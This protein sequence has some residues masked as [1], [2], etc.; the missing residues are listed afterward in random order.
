MKNYYRVMLGKKSIHAAEGFAGNFIGV[1]DATGVGDLTPH[2][3]DDFREFNKWFIPV[4]MSRYPEKTKIAAGL[5]GGVD[6]MI[7][8]GIL[9]GDVILSPDGSG[10]YRVGEVVGEYY[11]EPDAILTH[12]RHV[13]WSNITIPK[14]E[15][16]EALRNSA[17]SIGT[18]STLTKYADELTQ[19]LAEEP[20]TIVSTD[21]TVE[22]VAEFALESHLEDF[23]VK[24]WAHTELGRDY[25]IYEDDGEI[26]QQLQTDTGRLD[27]LAIS[28]DKK[29]LLVLE[30]KK[31]RA[32]DVVV[33]QTLRYMGY[34]QEELA[35]DGQTV[36]GAIIAHEDDLRIRRALAVIP[37]VSFYRYQV[38]FKL[39]KA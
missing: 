5:A 32:S 22:D 10:G 20:P 1:N 29:R 17:G 33:G 6:W 16:S 13:T 2:L 38:S 14:T 7:A 15:M 30:L 11:Y 4:F 12:R 37:S 31:G 39:A 25:D 26:G 23:L 21:A 28:K 24:N 35:S 27:I 18:I 3:R 34:V 19:F 9:S 8:K 36:E